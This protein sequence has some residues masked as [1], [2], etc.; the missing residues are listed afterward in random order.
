MGVELII[1]PRLARFAG[2]ERRFQQLGKSLQE[3]LNAICQAHPDLRSRL[4]DERG[5]LYP[6]LA[7]LYNKRRISLLDAQEITLHDGD[8]LEIMMLASGG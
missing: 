5:N 1:P 8:T 2:G 3:H 4:L 6:Y 7:V